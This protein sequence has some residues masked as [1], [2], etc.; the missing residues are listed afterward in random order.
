MAFLQIRKTWPLAEPHANR[1]HFSFFFFS[2]GFGSQPSPLSVTVSPASAVRQLTNTTALYCQA[3]VPFGYTVTSTQWDRTNFAPMPV[4]RSQQY[5]G[6]T[7]LVIMDHKQPDSGTYRCTVEATNQLGQ[8]L[9]GSASSTITVTSKR[10]VVPN[11]LWVG[12]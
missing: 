9:R 6:N 7:Y 5:T 10:V 4:G 3:S 1:E 8:T 12:T 11:M 2:A